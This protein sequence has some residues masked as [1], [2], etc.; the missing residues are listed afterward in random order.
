MEAS[1]NYDM[2]RMAPIDT[3][4]QQNLAAEDRYTSTTSAGAVAAGKVTGMSPQRLEH[5]VR[6]YFG[7][8]GTQALNAS[9]YMLRDAMDLGANPRRDL[10]KPNNVFVMGDFFKEA[11]TS[12]GK[13]VNRFYAMQGEI[14]ELYAS[15]RYAQS[16]GD[17]ERAADLMASPTLRLRSLY[18]AG[19]KQISRINKQIKAIGN[20]RTLTAKEKNER[21]EDLT[22]LR[23]SIARRIDEASRAGYVGRDRQFSRDRRDE[24]Y[25]E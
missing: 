15:A 22:R 16:T 11:G 19:D 6:G 9:D 23:N 7:W 5:M 13:Y 1:F 20:N 25:D 24:T 12:S 21:I 17:T 3:M 18:Q 2:F 10:S 4:G 8:L 14:D